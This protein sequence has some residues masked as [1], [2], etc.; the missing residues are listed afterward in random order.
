MQGLGAYTIFASNLICST[1]Y[2]LYFSYT[3]K[4]LLVLLIVLCHNVLPAQELAIPVKFLSNSK[5]GQQRFLGIDA[6]GW[7]YTIV[8]NEF[9]KQKDNHILKY[10]NLSL[11]EI[12]K[13]D[14][15]NPLQIVLFY[16]KFNTAVLLDNQLNETSRI[17]FSNIPQPLIAEAAGLASQN[18]LWVY[19][20]STQQ[21]GLYDLAQGS[22]KTITPPFTDNIKYYQNDYNYFYWIDST[23][24]CFMANVFGNVGTLGTVPAYDKV[25]ILSAN[26]LILQKDNKLYFYN[27]E[28]QKQTPI[29][30]TEKSFQSFHYA[31]QILTIFTDSEINT[32]KIILPK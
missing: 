24:K 32:Y 16:R 29:S 4:Q 10:R 23:N 26:E 17:N 19:D 22:F 11:G 6:F 18:R 9:R 31:S 20:I 5:G 27:L 21:L 13:A 25:Q 2:F 15:Q 28:K 12:Y 14:L 7:E 8:D 3:M 30:V 1:G